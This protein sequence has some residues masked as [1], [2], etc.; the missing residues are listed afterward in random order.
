MEQQAREAALG[1]MRQGR[2]NQSEP[3]HGTESVTRRQACRAGRAPCA[4]PRIPYCP[5]P[6]PPAPPTFS[7]QNARAPQ[8]RQNARENSR[9]AHFIRLTP[10][11]NGM[12]V[13]LGPIEPWKT[14]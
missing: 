10:Q 11:L 6:R 14:Q 2:G 9:M 4:H 12:T 3:L 8:V 13:A 5:P 1:L 7:P